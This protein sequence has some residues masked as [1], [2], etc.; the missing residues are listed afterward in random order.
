M[1]LRPIFV[2]FCNVSNLRDAWQA[3]AK[4]TPL[5]KT[6]DLAQHA[7]EEVGPAQGCWMCSQ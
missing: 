4:Q 7:G 3:M 2:Y 1:M 6:V 5:A